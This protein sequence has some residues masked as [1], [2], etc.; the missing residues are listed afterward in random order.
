MHYRPESIPRGKGCIAHSY[1]SL[2]RLSVPSSHFHPSDWQKHSASVRWWETS[3]LVFSSGSINSCQLFGQQFG[4]SS[5]KVKCTVPFLGCPAAVFPA[6]VR[7]IPLPSELHQSQAPTFPMRNS[8]VVE[9]MGGR[10]SSAAARVRHRLCPRHRL[11]HCSW[12]QTQFLPF[13]LRCESP[14]ILFSKIPLFLKSSS[15]STAYNREFWSKR[16]HL[17][18]EIPLLRMYLNEV[19]IYISRTRHICYQNM[20]NK[21]LIR[22][23]G[24][25]A[26]YSHIMRFCTACYYRNS[27]GP[28]KLM[29]TLH[30]NKL[31]VREEYYV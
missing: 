3:V 12:P 5:Q 28:H 13:Q 1:S 30:Q 27:I 17:N 25:Q 19:C 8:L 23:M 29:Q 21:I 31:I 16:V 22:R 6:S 4:N 14:A 10:L 24:Q 15:D 26:W 2:R 20:K 7:R 9:G 11:R 18:S